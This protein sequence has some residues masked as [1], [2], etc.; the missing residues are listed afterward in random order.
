MLEVPYSLETAQR[1]LPQNSCTG[2]S[3]LPTPAIL[4]TQSLEE[5]IKKELNFSRFHKISTSL[6]WAGLPGN[7]SALNRHISLRRQILATE[8]T[9][10]HLV[11]GGGAVYIKPLPPFLL[12]RNF[13]IE[14]IAPSEVHS[15][16]RWMLLSYAKLIRY[17]SDLLVAR[18]SGLLSGL[19]IEQEISWPAWVAFASEI[20]EKICVEEFEGRFWYGDLRLDRLNIIF[21]FRLGVL[22]GFFLSYDKYGSFFSTNFKWVAISFLYISV[23]L[24]AMQVGL[25]GMEFEQ[26]EDIQRDMAIIS[27]WFAVF[28][29]ILVLFVLFLLGVIFLGLF[30]WNYWKTRGFDGGMKARKRKYRS[31]PE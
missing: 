3:N 25:A 28:C 31:S 2:S 12:N 18:Q 11:W 10:L 30:V 13:F 19:E 16:A 9:D 6:F 23:V 14:A 29:M 15:A 22:R 4:H 7:V 17:P 24:S 8:Q 26:S 20:L 5:Y 21:R 1:I 27:F